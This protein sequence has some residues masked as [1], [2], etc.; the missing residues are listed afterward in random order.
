MLNVVSLSAMPGKP[1]L[2]D[3]VTP[4]VMELLVSVDAVAPVSAVYDRVTVA[5]GFKPLVLST[6]TLVPVSC[7]GA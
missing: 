2:T 1:S 7:V 6:T 5:L 4:E 3:S